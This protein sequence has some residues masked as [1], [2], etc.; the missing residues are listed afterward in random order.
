MRKHLRLLMLLCLTGCTVLLAFP[1]V[2][3][4]QDEEPSAEPSAEE[5]EDDQAAKHFANGRKLYSEAKYKEAIEELLKAYQLR[6]AP[7]ILLNIA[8]TYE[9]LDNKTEALK[10]YKEFLQ[11]ARLV[12]PN[13][14]QVEAVVKKLEQEARV[15]T[16]AV[17]SSAGTDTPE[18]SG[19]GEE[20]KV[21]GVRRCQQMIHT[22][23]DSAKVGQPITIMVELPPRLE[24]DR[25]VLYI[26]LG[27]ERRFRELPMELQGETYVARVP[28]RFVTST[29]LQYYVRAQKGTGRGRLCAEA[30][31]KT[32]PNIVVIEGGRA[33]I[34][35]PVPQI[36]VRSPYRA[37]IWV[38]GAATVAFLAAGI[39][40]AV[41]ARDRESAIERWAD[42]KSCDAACQEGKATPKLTFDNKARDWESEGKTFATLG[43]VL[44]PIGVAAAAATGFLWYMDRKYVKEER[45]RIEREGGPR[46]E[47]GPI[48]FG[49]P[50]IGAGAG[51][52]MGQMTF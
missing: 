17:T 41:M 22:P 44:I 40:G 37:W 8:R 3:R 28:A 6:P 23:V 15:K 34:V 5:E 39:T 18:A 32:T 52:L 31:T 7:P 30:G 51:G 13:R 9:K 20:P 24:V 33:P 36:D 43:Q 50:W 12:D 48:I 4:A 11:K 35:G 21:P 25:V 1:R 26:R 27:G 38:S 47:P 19:T 29:S 10:Y 45:A 2:S 42:E 16:G 14:P 49:A 46:G